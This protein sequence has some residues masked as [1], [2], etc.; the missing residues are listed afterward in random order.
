MRREGLGKHH[1]NK[2]DK[3]EYN[4]MAQQKKKS[5]TEMMENIS[6]NKMY[7]ETW[8]PTPATTASA[9]DDSYI[10]T[11]G[12]PDTINL[13][14]THRFHHDLIIPGLLI[15]LIKIQNTNNKQRRNTHWLC[16][17]HRTWMLTKNKIAVSTITWEWGA[18]K[19]VTELKVVIKIE[20]GGAGWLVTVQ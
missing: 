2:N 20:N 13:S 11:D 4:A 1:N 14:P 15:L 3:W 6:R 10:Q 5:P 18:Y 9:D 12:L 19:K 8:P 17:K 16:Y 7:G